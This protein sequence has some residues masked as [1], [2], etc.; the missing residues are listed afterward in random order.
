MTALLPPI[1]FN[2][3]EALFEQCTN[4][5]RQSLVMFIMEMRETRRREKMSLLMAD[6]RHLVFLPL[7][8]LRE[9]SDFALEDAHSWMIEKYPEA[10]DMVYALE[11]LTIFSMNKSE[12][13]T[14]DLHDVVT[15]IEDV[16]KAAGGKSAADLPAAD[17]VTLPTGKQESTPA[18]AR[19]EP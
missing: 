11:V 16:W 1:Q 14:Q 2:Q 13:T 3:I 8:K 7:E 5:E 19:Q 4:E 18:R 10:K 17:I 15:T 12:P 6:P 9:V